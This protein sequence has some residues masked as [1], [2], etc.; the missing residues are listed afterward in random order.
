MTAMSLRGYCRTLRERIA[1]NPAIRMTRLTTMARTG[2]LTKRSVNFTVDPS[3]IFRLGG[4]VVGG[5]DLVVDADGGAVPE[6]EGAGGHDFLACLDARD[7]RDLVAAGAAQ[8]DELLPH[9]AI[10][11]AARSLHVLHD[12]DRIAVGRVADRGRR[13]GDDRAAGAQHDL[14]LDEHAGVQPAVHVAER[15]LDLDVPG[16]GVADRIDGRDASGQ[17]SARHALEGHAH[18]APD[19]RLADLLLGH[20]EVHIDRLQG[21]QGYDGIA[22]LEVLAEVHLPDA[23]EAREGRPDLLP[24]DGGADLAHP[25]LRLLVLRRGTV[26]IRLG[27]DA[28]PVEVGHPVQVETGEV[29]LRLRRGELRLLLPGVQLHEHFP[30]LDGLAGTEGDPVDGAGEGCGPRG[31]ARPRTA[32]PAPPP[33]ASDPPE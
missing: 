21:L 20:G 4:R 16:R 15:G 2:R 27:R 8:L 24:V 23:Q 14:R 7:H 3:V 11:L 30:G 13:E 29:P 10:A 6:L 17:I 12:E 18:A 25:G 19:A 32:P 31:C 28:L 33:D 1:C 26:V 5:L 9:P 22:T